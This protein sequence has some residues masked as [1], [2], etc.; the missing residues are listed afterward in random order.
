MYSYYL[1]NTISEVH[2]AF[3]KNSDNTIPVYRLYTLVTR[4]AKLFDPEKQNHNA[5]M[6]NSSNSYCFPD[7]TENSFEP[8][9]L[10]YKSMEP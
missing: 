5:Y 3:Q 4:Y 9:R 2:A 6:N 7:K 10:L 8:E 1:E